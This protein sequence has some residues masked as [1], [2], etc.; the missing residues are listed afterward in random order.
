MNSLKGKEIYIK[1]N[2]YHSLNKTLQ[3]YFEF[4]D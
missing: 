2:K 4:F 3:I 1:I